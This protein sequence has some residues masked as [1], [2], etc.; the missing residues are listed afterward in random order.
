MLSVRR[1]TLRTKQAKRAL[2][3]K[4]CFRISSELSG[5]TEK[6]RIRRIAQTTSEP[7]AEKPA[8]AEQFSTRMRYSGSSLALSVRCNLRGHGAA[9]LHGARRNDGKRGFSRRIGY[10]HRFSLAELFLPNDRDIPH[11]TTQRKAHSRYNLTAVPASRRV[12]E[13]RS[14]LV[15]LFRTLIRILIIS[16]GRF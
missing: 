5:L 4:S 15:V 1:W 12:V 9:D 7:N 16:A 3:A 10:R 14:R 2:M 8:F 13:H 11:W 6:T